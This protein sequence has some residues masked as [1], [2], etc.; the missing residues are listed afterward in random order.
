MANDNCVC[1]VT[2]VINDDVINY[3]KS[4]KNEIDGIMDLL[5]VYDNKNTID[6][7]LYSY[8][9][10]FMFNSIE[11]DNFF[12]FSD[13]RLSSS[14]IVLNELYKKFK[15]EHYLIMEYDIVLSGSFE[16]FITKINNEDNIDYIHIGYDNLGSPSNHWP[17]KFI[18]NY[19]DKIYF[20]WSQMY[21]ISYNY[22]VFLS[23]FIKENNT[24]Y[25]EFLL[26]SLAYNNNFKV[27][28]FE[29]YGYKFEISW[30]PAKTYEH[31]YVNERK[32]DTFYHPIKNTSLIFK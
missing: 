11:L 10:F 30:G 31:M 12:H 28:Q 29:N 18:K 17:I 1:F 9:N 13:K 4:I 8:F 20:S 24:L 27:K 14:F 19:E 3:L 7:T 26:P 23:E 22:L 15:Y 2:H 21:Y 5:V 16:N 6:E 25:Y 32:F